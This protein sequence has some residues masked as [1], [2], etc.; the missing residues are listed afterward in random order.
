MHLK[1]GGRFFHVCARCE[2]YQDTH[3]IIGTDCDVCTYLEGSLVSLLGFLVLTSGL[4]R[5]S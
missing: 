3:S 5:K 2:F 1:G 4:L